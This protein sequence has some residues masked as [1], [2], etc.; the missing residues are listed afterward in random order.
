VGVFWEHLFGEPVTLHDLPRRGRDR[1]L[2]SWPF[3]DEHVLFWAAIDNTSIS[4]H[5]L[6]AAP[7]R[8]AIMLSRPEPHPRSRTLASSVAVI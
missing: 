6:L 4:Q 8:T 1:R 5:T 3:S 2:P 7:A